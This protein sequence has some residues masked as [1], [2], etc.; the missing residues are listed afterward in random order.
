MSQTA[1]N[2]TPVTSGDVEGQNNAAA[3]TS[4]RQRR[5]MNMNSSDSKR[6]DAA[7]LA[8]QLATTT[9]WSET[10]LPQSYGTVPVNDTTVE[11]AEHSH[12]DDLDPP[13]AYSKRPQ[14]HEVQP[15]P[16]ETSSQSN[17]TSSNMPSTQP[18]YDSDDEVPA[19]LQQEP[20]INTSNVEEPLLDRWQRRRRCRRSKKHRLRDW[21]YRGKDKK[22]KCVRIMTILAVCA[23]LSLIIL[24]LIQATLNVV[25]EM[26]PK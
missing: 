13:P 11:R 15:N 18:Q 19:D 25:C 17:P 10:F 4:R 26:K 1:P 16:V 2:V 6:S 14:A 24:C 12:Q 20:S 22:R 23:G 5:S 8:Q 9:S 3:W 21:V 7:H